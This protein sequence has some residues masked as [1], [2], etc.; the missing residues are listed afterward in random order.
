MELCVQS[1]VA[2][3]G[4]VVTMDTGP[5]RVSVD[6]R[7]DDD[8]YSLT[9]A[10]SPLLSAP[11]GWRLTMESIASTEL[12]TNLVSGLTIVASATTELAMGLVASA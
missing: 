9:G 7:L 12:G 2:P 1:T 4:A 10:T 6:S 5:G 11:V 8:K 3:E